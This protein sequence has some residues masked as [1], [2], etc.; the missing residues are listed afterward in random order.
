MYEEYPVLKNIKLLVK[1]Y[2]IKN[3]SGEKKA[4]ERDVVLKEQY[5]RRKILRVIH[6]FVFF[7]NTSLPINLNVRCHR[8][9][10]CYFVYAGK[11]FLSEDMEMVRVEFIIVV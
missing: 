3:L 8:I 1:S 11:H 2:L 7:S 5:F 4:H 10:V 9:C 6:I